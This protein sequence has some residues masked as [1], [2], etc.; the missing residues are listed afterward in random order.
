MKIGEIVEILI[1]IKDQQHTRSI[2]EEAL[3]EACNLLDR[4]PSGEEATTY[5]PIKNRVV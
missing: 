3:I 1:V 4:L 2:E 5:E